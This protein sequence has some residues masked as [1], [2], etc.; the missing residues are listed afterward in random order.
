MNTFENLKPAKVF[1]YFAL[2]SSVPHG[3]GNTKQISDICVAFAKEHGLSYYQD[4]LNNVIIYKDASEGY[5]SSEPVILQGHLDMV[6]AKDADCPIDMEKEGLK[7]CTDG[8]WLWA[9]GTSL[10]ADNAVAVAVIMAILDDKSLAHPPIEAVFTVDEET[11]MD[12]AQGLDTKG[13]KGKRLINLDSEEEGIFTVG[14]AGGARVNCSLDCKREELSGFEFYKVSV[15]GL[16]G[17]HSGVEIDKGRG[18]SNRLMARML[19]DMCEAAD[20]RLCALEGGS[21][22]NVI[23]K[24]TEAVVA[25]PEAKVGKF[26]SMA[27]EYNAIYKNE[28]ATSD[29]GVTVSFEKC[30]AMAAVCAD[31]TKKL[32]CCL[33]IVPYHVQEMSM[34]IKGLVQTSLNLGVLKLLENSLEFSFAVRSSV[35]SQKEE[36]IRRVRATVECMG[37]KVSS[38]G[39]YPAWQYAKVSPLR[40][41][42][43]ESYKKLSGKEGEVMAI[44]AGLECGL[45]IEKIPGLDCISFGPDLRDV[46]STRERLNIPSTERMYQLVC[47]ILK[48]MK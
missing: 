2:L 32:L 39:D 6:C 20:I 35:T 45:F 28:L 48:G 10:G 19:F 41:L 33:Y 21:L 12:G 25:V 47:E 4:D 46:H 23:P 17:G 30:S 13:L 34:D 43:L 24:L 8:E 44:H 18:S 15:S 1:E 9:D 27:E 37:G 29:P 3:S 38:H 7:L 42:V 26:A 40:D 22:D 14:C 11:G 36:L 16:M 31:D 5:E